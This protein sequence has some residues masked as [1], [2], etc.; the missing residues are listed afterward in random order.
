MWSA[1]RTP[2]VCVHELPLAVNVKKRHSDIQKL[3]AV[4]KAK[5]I[6]LPSSMEEALPVTDNANF[7]PKSEKTA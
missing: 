6:A 7:D 4:L 1:S 3:K 2:F 5:E